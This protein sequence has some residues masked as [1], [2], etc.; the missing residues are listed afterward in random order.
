MNLVNLT[1]AVHRLGKIVA[2]D[3]RLQAQL[4][5]C[6]IFADLLAGIIRM[7]ETYSSNDVQPQ[8][9]S[10][11]L[12]ALA[13]IRHIDMQIIGLACDRALP[14][15]DRFKSFELSTMLWAI[16]KLATIDACV[17]LKRRPVN[18]IFEA[19]DKYILE[20]ISSME[21]RCLSMAVWAYA[22]A[23]HINHN[24][25]ARIA[26]QMKQT[27][28]TATCQEMGNTVWA[29]GTAN[30]LE[31]EL[32]DVLAERGRCELQAFKPQE[33]SNMLWGFAC[34][35]FFHE[36]FFTQA[37]LAARS[38]ELSAQHLAN[39]LW[40]YSRLRP[41][42]ILTHCTVLSL[43]PMCCEEI[44]KFKPQELS[45]VALS[46]A[47]AFSNYE[48]QSP[49]LNQ[50][51]DFLSIVRSALPRDMS[52]FST[53]SLANIAAAFTLV[54]IGESDVF[55]SFGLEAVRRAQTMPPSE[56][57][58]LFQVF[59]AGSNRSCLN[60]AGLLAMTLVDR[61]DSLRARDIKALSR[62]LIEYL[63]TDY[64]GLKPSRDLNR[65]EFTALC[66]QVA[67]KAASASPCPKS[68]PLKLTD[69]E[70]GTE[71]T[72]EPSSA[73]S[74]FSSHLA[75]S[76]ADS[77]HDVLSKKVDDDMP[78][79]VAKQQI[80]RSFF[81]SP[82]DDFSSQTHQ[83][84]GSPLS[85]GLQPAASRNSSRQP[86]SGSAVRRMPRS[87]SSLQ[88]SFQ[89][90]SAH[91]VENALQYWKGYAAQ[92][93][94]NQ[95]QPQPDYEVSESTHSFDSHQTS[96]VSTGIG[97]SSC[98]QFAGTSQ[99]HSY[100]IPALEAHQNASFPQEAYYSVLVP[101]VHHAA[102]QSQD[103]NFARVHHSSSVSWEEPLL[104]PFSED[105]GSGFLTDD[106][107]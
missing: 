95:S 64:I 37:A 3:I 83:R 102:S 21:F 59:L 86:Q 67:Q 105:D 87:V 77:Q 19:A 88:K 103:L 90:G 75:E 92:M 71:A 8:S 35:G 26:V 46:V 29:Y 2:H 89:R 84:T 32:F 4:K 28:H 20:H 76:Y 96:E 30:L 66:V 27:A 63:D 68:G 11:I 25:L 79:Y 85:P 49:V 69:F 23:K 40:S 104:P 10:N 100:S 24:V 18:L 70:L 43:L 61:V 74:E 52:S 22:T 12:W 97:T 42:H 15:I 82:S 73:I 80:K 58:H 1:T 93:Y 72:A 7:L 39:I 50:V 91:E 41:K 17:Q 56:L 48:E 99:Q 14:N 98:F 53:Q 36:D 106:G 13:S 31:V 38:K 65:Q 78:T 47:K 51:A 62:L 5:Q 81:S 94:T 45:I 60:V 101:V 55:A 6:P 57:V 34:C 44:N 16:T 107:F 54:R 9:V 33:L